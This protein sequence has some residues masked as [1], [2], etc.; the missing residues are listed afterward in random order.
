MGEFQIDQYIMLVL[1]AFCLRWYFHLLPNN[2]HIFFS[3][4]LL[5]GLLQMIGE[6]SV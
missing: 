4:N 2:F 5:Y 6:T 3:T 1:A